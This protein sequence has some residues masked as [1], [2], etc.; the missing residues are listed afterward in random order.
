MITFHFVFIFDTTRHLISHS[1][2]QINYSAIHMHLIH[3]LLS[4]SY[5]DLS[6]PAY[7]Y[8]SLIIAASD[9]ADFAGFPMV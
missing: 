4:I 9:L 7:L 5:S 2:F 6:A 1:T 3:H 8:N